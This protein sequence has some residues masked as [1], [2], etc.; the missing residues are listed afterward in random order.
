MLRWGVN[1]FFQSKEFQQAVHGLES[2]VAESVLREVLNDPGEFKKAY[3]TATLCTALEKATPK[4]STA[5]EATPKASTAMESA[6]E[7]IQR[8]HVLAKAYKA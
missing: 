4:A 5:M 6:N 3:T 7:C 1:R 8:M 2:L